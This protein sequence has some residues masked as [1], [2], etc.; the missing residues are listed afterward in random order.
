MESQFLGKDLLLVPDTNFKIEKVT[1]SRGFVYVREMSAF[2]KDVL[3]QS[4]RRTVPNGDPNKPASFELATENFRA[5]LAVLTLCD[6][7]GNLL[8][9]KNDATQLSK[10]LKASDMERIV[11]A[12][13]KLNVITEEDKKDLLKNSE[14]VLD[15]GSN[16]SSAEN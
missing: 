4:M 1:L 7:K 2:E 9:S 15:E 11:E 14:A 3:E 8:L 12:A 13:Q 5:K 16:S 10:S 6:E